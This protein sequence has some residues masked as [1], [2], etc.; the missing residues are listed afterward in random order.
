[1]E[2]TLPTKAA[3]D[4]DKLAVDDSKAND[5]KKGHL[6]QVLTEG[7]VLLL[8][9]AGAYFGTYIYEFGYARE[10][11]IPTEFITLSIQNLLYCGGFLFGFICACYQFI[12]MMLKIPELLNEP[13]ER[14]IGLLFFKKWGL[15]VLVWTLLVLVTYGHWSTLFF[16]FLY[17][18][19]MIL[20]FLPPRLFGSRSTYREFVRGSLKSEYKDVWLFKDT[21]M[22]KWQ[23][24]TGLFLLPIVLCGLWGVGEARSRSVFPFIGDSTEVI[25]RRYGDTLVIGRFDQQTGYLLNEFRVVKADEIKDRIV[26]RKVGAAWTTRLRWQD[27]R[28]LHPPMGNGREPVLPATHKAPEPDT[29]KAPEPDTHKPTNLAPKVAKPVPNASKSGSATTAEPKE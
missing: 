24:Y 23:G 8:V 20:D 13:E 10:L 14:G 22:R 18:F 11:N 5:P 21:Q 12:Q 4:A 17:L 15:A 3:P 26:M 19:P 27:V 2:K 16:G 6:S 7:L 25:L 1:M 9:T 29:H 28:A